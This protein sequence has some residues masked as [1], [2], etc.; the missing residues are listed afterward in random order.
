MGCKQAGGQT[1]QVGSA[2]GPSGKALQ[3]LLSPWVCLPAANS[4]RHAVP[5]P[6]NYQ[7]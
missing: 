7:R 4:L 2:P 6:R 3:E 1:L 5:V